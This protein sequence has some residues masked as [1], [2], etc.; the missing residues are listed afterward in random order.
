MKINIVT[1]TFGRYHRQDLAV[2]SWRRLSMSDFP[3]NVDVVDFQFEDEKANPIEYNIETLFVLKH[4]S[5][6]WVRGGTKKLPLVFEIL[7]RASEMECDYFIFTN[8]D[9]ILMPKLINYIMDN[10]PNAM[11]ISRMDIK[12]IESLKAIDEKNIVP[13]RYETFGSDVFVFNRQWFLDNIALFD[14]NYLLG[15]WKW[16][17]VYAG[18]IKILCPETPLGVGFP[19]F[20]FHIHHGIG[21]CTTEC[22]E[23]QYNED[24]MKRHVIHNMAA[25]IMGYYLNNFMRLRSDTPRFLNLAPQELER[26]IAY[27]KQFPIVTPNYL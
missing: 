15:M 2:E 27:F 9:V 26:E 3:E 22:P 10:Q 21:S 23:K 14:A 4:S 25:N 1:N 7:M 6:D 13:V 24:C 11:A 20:A 18:L 16:D 19:P 5:K 12:H 8:S 17:N